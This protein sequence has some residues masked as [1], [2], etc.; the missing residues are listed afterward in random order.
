MGVGLSLNL[1]D[2]VFHSS[3]IQY[4]RYLVTYYGFFVVFDPADCLAMVLSV[5]WA[6]FYCCVL[7]KKLT[8]SGSLLI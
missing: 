2:F 6:R 8:K 3:C 7:Q 5:V 1:E 4:T